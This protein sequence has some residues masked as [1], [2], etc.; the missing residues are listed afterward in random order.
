MLDD[1]VVDTNVLMHA[2][3]PQ[4]KRCAESR[5]LVN[6]LTVGTTLLCMDEG[7]DIDQSHN[8]SA[9]GAEYLANVRF[10]SPS[11]AMIVK[12]ALEAR[13]RPLPRRAHRAAARR[14]NQL[15]RKR[16]DRTFLNVAVNSRSSFF[17]SHDFKD[18][19]KAKRRTIRKELGVRVVEAC[20]C[21]GKL[22]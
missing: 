21:G 18:F 9:I 12:L 2:D 10:G 16:T 8:R 13:I 1:I 14:I 19:Q 15:V 20:D 4:E 22:A 3:N 17:V 7:F 6:D 11:H 5:A